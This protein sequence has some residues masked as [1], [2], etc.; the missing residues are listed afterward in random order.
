MTGV[1]HCQYDYHQFSHL[2]GFDHHDCDAPSLYGHYPNG[3]GKADFIEA[4]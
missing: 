1:L 4:A 3:V 2:L